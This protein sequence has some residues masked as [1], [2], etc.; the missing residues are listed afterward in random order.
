MA[1]KNPSPKTRFK[2]GQSGNKGG[3]PAGKRISTWMVEL[4]QLSVDELVKTMPGLPVNG[5]IAASRIM[6]AINGGK[7]A[8]GATDIV[9]D[10]TEGKVTQKVEGEITK[11]IVLIFPEDGK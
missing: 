10:R 1:N 4:G 11:R 5:Q 9:L 7:D 3:S 8:N 2:P 6:A